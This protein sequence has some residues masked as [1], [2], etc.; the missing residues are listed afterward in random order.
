[1]ICGDLSLEEALA[2]ALRKNQ[3]QYGQVLGRG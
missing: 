2:I 1:M 3:A